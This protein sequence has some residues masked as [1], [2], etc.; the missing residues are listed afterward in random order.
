MKKQRLFI[1]DFEAGNYLEIFFISAVAAVLIIRLFLE[2]TGYPQLGGSKLHIAHMLWGGLLMMAS[3]VI[4]FS[5]LSKGSNR[6]GAVI[7]G[8]GF[9]AFIDEVGK[10]VTQ[11][12]DYFFKPAVAL[13]YVTFIF[14]FLAIRALHTGKRYSQKEYLMNALQEM[15]EVVLHDL[16]KEEKLRALHFLDRSESDDPLVISL[17]DLLYRV[18]SVPVEKPGFWTRLKTVTG[19]L[20]QRIA[21]TRWFHRGI[22]L[23]FLGQLVIKLS[24]AIVLVFFIGLRWQGILNVNI[25]RNIA[26]WIQTLSFSSGAQLASSLLSGVFVFWGILR[27]RKS[28]L[29]AFRMFERSILISIF[30]TQIFTFYHEQFGALIGLSFNIM[31]LLALKYMIEQE[32]SHSG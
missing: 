2:I 10:F 14:I 6:L 31:V 16:D 21:R 4:V 24:Y 5:F 27:I 1:R 7:G 15:E 22:I 32:K 8:I 19:H 12:N 13:I 30:L 28:R 17:R 26:Y 20:Y 11:D 3:L 29:T 23:F 9:G 25:L 18:D